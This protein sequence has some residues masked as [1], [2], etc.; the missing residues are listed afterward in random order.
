MSFV[1]T[2]SDYVKY[3]NI[4]SKRIY[5]NGDYITDLDAATGDGDH[6]TNI[7]MGFQNLVAASDELRNMPICEVFKKIGMLMMS[8][9]GGSSG[10]LY[11]GAYIAASKLFQAKTA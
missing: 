2:S 10:I 1:I 11:G 4:V 5:E 7:N 6:W 3:I 8:N 9:I